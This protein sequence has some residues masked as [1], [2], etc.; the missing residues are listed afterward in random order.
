MLFDLC[1]PEV[2]LPVVFEGVQNLYFRWIYIRKFMFVSWYPASLKDGPLTSAVSF[3]RQFKE[4]IL[5]VS[6]CLNFV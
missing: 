6:S 1:R 5:I 3:I 2:G 4:A